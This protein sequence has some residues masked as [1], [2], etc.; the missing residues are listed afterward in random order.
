MHPFDPMLFA[1]GGGILGARDTLGIPVFYIPSSA[2][3]TWL[4]VVASLLGQA[5]E[6][7]EVSPS[8]VEGEDP[9]FRL[10]PASLYAWPC[11]SA[12]THDNATWPQPQPSSHLVAIPFVLQPRR[13]MTVPQALD[14]ICPADAK[15]TVYKS[16]TKWTG[17]DR[18]ELAEAVAI[19]HYPGEWG[20]G[21]VEA[22]ATLT[23]LRCLLDYSNDPNLVFAAIAMHAEIES[24]YFDPDHLL[25]RKAPAYLSALCRTGAFLG[26]RHD[27]DGCQEIMMATDYALDMD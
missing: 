18:H 11:L 24:S 8:L 17:I 1:A 6:T 7:V 9:P 13:T 21:G 15:T 10:V 20:G 16:H 4:P 25:D 19:Y 12:Y 27:V 3:S 2:L 22:C 5:V 14:H 26:L 23:A